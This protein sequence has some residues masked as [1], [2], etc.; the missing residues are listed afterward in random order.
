MRL[1]IIP[2][3]DLVILDGDARSVD[4]TELRVAGVHAVQWNNS[5]GAVERKRAPQEHISSI[6]DY[7][8]FIDAHSRAPRP[9][10]LPTGRR[11]LAAEL[12]A[13][14]SRI[15]ALEIDRASLA[16]RLAALEAKAR[17]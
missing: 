8:P 14:A 9:G 7:Q 6:T 1:T 3:D 17:P 11:D 4:L 15:A 16:A 12:D 5:E 13:L 10:A 2:D